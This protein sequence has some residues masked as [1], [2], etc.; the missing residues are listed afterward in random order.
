MFCV[1]EKNQEDE[2]G[3]AGEHPYY[4]VRYQKRVLPTHKNWPKIRYPSITEKVVCDDGNAIHA[5]S[6]FR[7]SL[8]KENCY[9]NHFS[10]PDGQR[11]IF[12]DLFDI[13][14]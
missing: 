10:L 9:R 2:L 13:D 14:L 3:R 11:E 12:G 5:W 7:T 1:F 8:G 4:M 6:R